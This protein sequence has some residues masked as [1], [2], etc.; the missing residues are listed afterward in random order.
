MRLDVP[1]ILQEKNS[2]N[3]QAVCVQMILHYYHDMVTMEEI[4][5]GLKPYLIHESGMHS[6][7]PAI[8]LAE[9]GYDVTYIAHDLGVIDRDIEHV[10]EKDVGKLRDKLTEIP[11]EPGHYRREKLEL[12]IKVIEAGAKYSNDIP[13]LSLFNGLLEQKIPIKIGVR[14]SGLQA[15]PHK[16]SNHSVVVVG[17]EGSKYVIND[18]NPY[19]GPQYII[20]GKQLLMAWYLNG[21]RTLIAKLEK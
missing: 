2:T 6:Q 5:N 9:R 20:E 3:C 16:D 19:Y 11:E 8:W 15:S 18:P 21:A 14:G 10:S 13:D 4:A 17:K 7:G 12:D 1:Q